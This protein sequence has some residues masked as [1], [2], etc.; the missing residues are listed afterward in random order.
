MGLKLK[1]IGQ[2]RRLRLRSMYM[3]EGQCIV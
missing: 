1:V 2:A 3:I